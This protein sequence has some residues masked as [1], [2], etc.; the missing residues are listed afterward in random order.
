MNAVSQQHSPEV[1]LIK[2]CYKE[3]FGAAVVDAV[4][5][6]AAEERTLRRYYHLDGLT[7]EQLGSLYP[8]RRITSRDRHDQTPPLS[9]AQ[10]G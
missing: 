5:M 10:T 3:A 8:V 1:V 6:F 2:R 9:C 4:R 7:R